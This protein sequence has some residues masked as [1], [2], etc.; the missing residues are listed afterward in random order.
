MKKLSL[1]LAFLLICSSAFASTYAFTRSGGKVSILYYNENGQKSLE[2]VIKDSGL[3]GLPM[4]EPTSIPSDR[5]N[6]DCWAVLGSEVVVDEACA[7]SQETASLKFDAKILLG[8][9]YQGLPTESALKLAPYTGAMQSM[10]DWKNFAGIRQLVEGLV[11]QGV[12]TSEEQTVIYQAFLNQ[13]IDL[14][15]WTE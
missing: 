14:T 4:I 7:T 6:R 12:V 9:L 8:D 13:G 15:L 5:T 3:E 10:M 2:Q 11:A 1:S